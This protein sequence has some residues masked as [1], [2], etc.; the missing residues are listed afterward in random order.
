M[1]DVK[2]RSGVRRKTTEVAKRVAPVPLGAAGYSLAATFSGAPPLPGWALPLIC[3][4]VA[5]LAVTDRLT[6]F[7][8]K[9]LV[10][11]GYV[12]D[13]RRDD[14]ADYLTML[15]ELNQR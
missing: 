11:K 4:V 1:P 2:P 15:R 8:L 12:K 3:V 7:F 13:H 6:D 14:A 10:I 5:V 9:L